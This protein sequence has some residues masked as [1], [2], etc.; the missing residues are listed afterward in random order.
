MQPIADL[1][2]V[3]KSFGAVRALGG[4]DLALARGE[5][6]GLVGHNGA[7][8][9]TLM[10]VLAGVIGLMAYMSGFLGNALGISALGAAVLLFAWSGTSVVGAL[11]ARRIPARVS[12][13]VQL[14]IGLLVFIIYFNLLSAGKAWIEKGSVPVAVGLWWAHG[15][16]LLLTIVLL[17]KSV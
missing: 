1:G 9:S 11:L 14:A 6:L 16:M 7:G 10:N 8:K 2:G 4:V 13:R 12:G 15:L 3:E 17:V 5:C